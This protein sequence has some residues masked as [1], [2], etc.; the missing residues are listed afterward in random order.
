MPHSE[1]DGS[2]LWH[3]FITDV[4]DRK[5][6]EDSLRQS[7]EQ[8]EQYAAALESSNKAL[9]SFN[10][11]V[12]SAT[13]AKSE[14]LA[15]MSHEIRTPMT[16]I[17]GFADVL[18]DEAGLDR[19]PPERARRFGT[20]QRNGKHLLEL[21]NDILDLSKVEAGKMQIEPVR[22]SPFGLL[23][24]VVSLMRVRADAKHLKLETDMAGP[25]PETVLTDPLRLR[26]VLV[27]LVG[28]AIKFTDQ[29]EVRITV[30][31]VR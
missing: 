21:I 23:A 4:T 6:M 5:Q 28:N 27:N 8:A 25:L 1:Q 18:L 16:A 15:N 29:G 30:R 7:K 10:N 11:V 20:I 19:S 13:H 12:E 24:E 9:E 22:C 14:F 26:Q 31:L 17:L 2:V 3:G